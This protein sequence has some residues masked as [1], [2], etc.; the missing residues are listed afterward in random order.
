MRVVIRPCRGR[1]CTGPAV[2]PP[3]VSQR[4]GFTL[5]E[6][7]VVIAIIGILVGLML[8][9]VQAVREAARRMQCQN[10]LKQIGLAMQNYHSAYRKFPPG[11]IQVRPEVADGKQFAWSAMVLP[12]LEQ[13]AT[14]DRINFD[15]PFDDPINSDVAAKVIP[16]YLCP[17]TPRMVPLHYGRAAIDYGGI[18]GERIA[19]HNYPPRGVMIHDMAI[20]FRDITDGTSRTLMI[21]EDAN[22]PD[23]Q[24]INA[25]NLFDQAFP[26]N[27]AP[28]FENDIRSFHAQGANGL[29]ADG[30]VAFLS[31]HMDLYV[32]A[33]LCTRNG[34]EDIPDLDR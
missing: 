16:T 14:Y 7:L 34:N 19:S 4:G 6:L 11:G 26:I 9:A 1:F 10:H 8:P 2:D 33:A 31:E 13:S 25:W 17:T 5:V 15:Y 20:R 27:R 32:L 18:Y 30:S 3:I 24:W 28:K 12:F 23:G 22:F 21:A 29:F